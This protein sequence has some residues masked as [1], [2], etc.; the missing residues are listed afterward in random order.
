[1]DIKIT[2]DNGSFYI[3][4]KK[5]KIFTEDGYYAKFKP[6]D[7]VNIENLIDGFGTVKFW[8]EEDLKKYNIHYSPDV[9]KGFNIFLYKKGYSQKYYYNNITYYY[10]HDF[11]IK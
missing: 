4:F 5:Y 6:V 11:L 10:T 8:L 2:V 7:I 3:N 9:G 1:M